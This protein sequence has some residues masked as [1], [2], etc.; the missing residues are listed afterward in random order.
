MTEKTQLV[1][2]EE[3]ELS[4]REEMNRSALEYFDALIEAKEELTRE[5]K[6]IQKKYLI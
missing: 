3:P 2:K 5:Q 6:D 1:S 4:Y